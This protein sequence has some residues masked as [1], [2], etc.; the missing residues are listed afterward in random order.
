MPLNKDKIDDTALAL[1]YLTLHDG[2]GLE[3][4]RLGHARPSA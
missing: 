4:F 1:F 2:D 3:R